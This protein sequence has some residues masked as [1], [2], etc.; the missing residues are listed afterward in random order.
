MVFEARVHSAP[1]CSGLS[2]AAPYARGALESF[3][4]PL[5]IMVMTET[6]KLVE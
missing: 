5:S 1:R 2:P 3:G 6:C 4:T